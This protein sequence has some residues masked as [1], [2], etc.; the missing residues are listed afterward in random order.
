M[1]GQK[2]WVDWNGRATGWAAK[3]RHMFC[4]VLTSVKR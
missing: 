2:S 4:A 3:I 1:T